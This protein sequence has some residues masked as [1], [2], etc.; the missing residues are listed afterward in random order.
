MFADLPCAT[1]PRGIKEANPQTEIIIFSQHGDETC[2]HRA[3]E[4]GARA[5][6]LRSSRTTGL[7]EAIRLVSG[8]Q[9]YLDPALHSA[10]IESYLNKRGESVRE[11]GYEQLSKRER[12][13]FQMLV[14]GQS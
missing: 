13:V 12:E 7:I 10:I 1:L 11:Q 5:Y 4:E 2:V 6:V 9:Y 14:K 8:G 3:L